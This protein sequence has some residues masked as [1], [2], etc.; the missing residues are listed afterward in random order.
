VEWDGELG[1]GCSNN[2][3]EV[4]CAGWEEVT[5]QIFHRTDN[6]H[7]TESDLF[8]A[9]GAEYSC[10]Y[11]KLPQAEMR[12]E[13]DEDLYGLQPRYVSRSREWIG[14]GAYQRKRQ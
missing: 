9:P 2:V 12:R 7:T 8:S 14:L 11:F 10:R 4:F 3:E 13:K 6:G 1:G 5:D